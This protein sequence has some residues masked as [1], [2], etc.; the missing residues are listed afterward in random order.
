MNDFLKRLNRNFKIEKIPGM[1]EVYI[2]EMSVNERD[3]F[4]LRVTRMREG[5][6]AIEF[7]ALLIRYCMCDSQG[8]S[9]CNDDDL[10]E[11]GALPTSTIDPLFECA[12]RLNQLKDVGEKAPK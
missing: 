8:Q 5:N 12:S 3:E 7:R 1:D 4:E 2:R 9:V 11:I 10:K 6:H